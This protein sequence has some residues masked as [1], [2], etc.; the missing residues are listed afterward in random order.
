MNNCSYVHYITLLNNVNPIMKKIPIN[1]QSGFTKRVNLEILLD[2]LNLSL[3][4]ST[5]IIVFSYL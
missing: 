5:I 4:D 1:E 2:S 3:I